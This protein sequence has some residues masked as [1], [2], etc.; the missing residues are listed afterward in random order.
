MTWRRPTA[1]LWLV[2]ALAAGAVLCPTH[3]NALQTGFQAGQGSDTITVSPESGPLPK[4][5]VHRT[6]AQEIT[7]LIQPAPGEKAAAA[8]RVGGSKLVKSVRAIPGGF[9]IQLSTSGFGYV[10]SAPSG[11]LQIQ[12]FSDP[13][14]SR[15]ENVNKKAEPKAAPKAETSAE[16]KPAA[17]TEAKTEL[18]NKPPQEKP[19]SA[20]EQKLAEQKRLQEAKAAEAAR[21]K[22]ETEA[23]LEL[24]AAA[25]REKEAAARQPKP[26]AQ[27]ATPAP[28]PP[29]TS[30]PQA[31]VAPQPAPQP[32]QVTPGKADAATGQ[33]YF[34]VPY[35]MRAPVSKTVLGMPSGST[36]TLPMVSGQG[37]APS[38]PAPTPAAPKQAAHESTP[39]KV[40]GGKLPAGVTE[41]PILQDQHVPQAAPA[42]AQTPM[43]PVAAEHAQ[44][45]LPPPAQPTP[46]DVQPEK[47]KADVRFR[48][49][50]N[51]PEQARLAEIVSGTA[52]F[53]KAAAPGQAA[54]PAK[55][56]PAAQTPG[57]RP[58]E[59]RQQ[60]QKTTMP[61]VA[62]TT[63]PLPAV[64]PGAVA[65]HTPAAPATPQPLPAEGG[66]NA[67]AH[68]P[69]KEPAKDAA[70]EQANNTNGAAPKEPGKEEAKDAHGAAPKEAGKDKAPEGPHT[71]QQIKDMLL[72]AQSDMS[73]GQWDSAVKSL[74]AMLNEP[75]L[76]GALREEVL[77][78]LADAYM[79]AY[80]DNYA[81]NYDKVAGAQMMA[82]NSNQ[83][84][85]QVPRALL[86]LGLLNLKVGNLGEAKAYFNIIKKKYKIDQNAAMVPYSLGEY[87]RGKGDL[88][89][90]ADNYQELIQDYPDSKLAKETAYTLA[91][92]LRKLGE[93]EKAYKIIDYIDK[94][95]PLFYMEAPD[96]LRLE[97]EIEEKVGKLAQAKDHY[98]TYYNLNPAAEFA[99]VTLVRVG[100]IYLRQDKRA[101]AKEVYQKAVHDFP[102]SEGGL[103]A[104]MRIA[105]EG[106]YDD[107]TMTEM[108]SL[109]GK[110]QSLKP[111]ETYE[112]IVK[113]YPQSPLAPLAL[114]KLGMWQFYSKAY[115]DAIGS[116]NS[117]L[118]KY[119]KSPLIG[120]AKELGFQSFLL[121]LPQLVQEG[122]YQRVMQLFDSAPFVK[123]SQDKIGD[124]ARMA[125]AVSAWKR[126][127]PERA[128]QL[129]G[130]FLGKTQVPK[131]S[132]MAL[133]LAM[134][135]FME[136]KE[137]G[138]I[139]SLAAKASKAWKL[140]PRQ[141]AQ[142]EQARAMA[143]ENQ[144]ESEKSIP[145]WTRIASDPATDLPTR[146]FATYTLAKDAARKQDM[147]RLFALSQEALGLLLEARGDKD[148]I[149]DCLLM[150]ITA[151]ER[152]GRY[153][154]T[155]KWAKEFDRIISD[156]DPDW[157]P[158]RLRLAGIYRQGGKF[159][160]WKALLSDIVKKKPGTVY[161]RM[162]AQE[163]E[164]SALDQRL[165]KYLQNNVGR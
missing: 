19:L 105:E 117:F 82:M 112:Y 35:S 58:W 26:S 93:Y 108:V 107:P 144:G 156:K 149:K 122:N 86:N 79:Q 48:A 47:G 17:K 155:L 70:K 7:V 150:S 94:R 129:A 154:E 15:W 53:P 138:R 137:W 1:P 16:T 5:S 80:R 113:K 64:A 4:Y 39:A 52:A 56:A 165:Q 103:V 81:A 98:W 11:K 13:I 159:D 54:A 49:D 38:A 87:Y 127:E 132:E 37:Q 118:E 27:A 100:D 145:L 106:I 74:R 109:F 123:E 2:A 34:S 50:R 158:L 128:L 101:A 133:D 10:H 21:R 8:P 3:G 68:G 6:G 143:L 72:K 157:A 66:G 83:K 59:I 115:L 62:G 95:W 146:A 126:G 57:A 131:Y 130:K 114:I 41:K 160:E 135:I 25:K 153:N 55:I 97:A 43:P 46:I 67:S 28:A 90:A 85:R 14:G 161:A 60:V 9:K 121:A 134:N 22:A 104:R 102:G 65:E 45:T 147:H 42:T 152:S 75:N 99:D 125:I 33:P 151:T 163:L 89:K 20:K 36:A 124:E 63:A 78:S 140:S 162:A 116:A 18:P 24:E 12:L 29:S 141:Q 84:S 61:T 91:Q 92:T 30:A 142:F 96:F 119:P 77:Y 73:A 31:P 23:R 88:K 110:P 40:V 51:T 148:K 139:A 71:E 76:K 136:R 32:A 111:N 120:K 44:P 164:S 69:T